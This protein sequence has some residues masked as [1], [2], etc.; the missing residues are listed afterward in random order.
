M[1]T[2]LVTG[3]N[4][5]VGLALAR[6]WAARGCLVVATARRPD[7]ATELRAL[8][9]EVP[10]LLQIHPLDVTNPADCERLARDLG[11]LAIDVLVCNAGVLSG[12]GPIEDPAYDL[13]AW[14]S[15]LMT[16]VAGVFFTIR[17]IVPLVAAA[18]AGKIAVISSIMG[19]STRA[20]GGTYAYRASKAAA[21]NLA[22]NMAPELAQRGIA[23]GAYHPGWVKTDMGGAGADITVEES[24]AGL[25]ARIDA[26]TLATTGVF[27]DYRGQPIPF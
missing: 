20:P 13:D 22:R 9:A 27:E 1:P 26:L 3:A 8:S 12:R 19:S 4:R 6:V 18:P 15:Q 5:G 21:V 24:A 10:G 17:A 2:C 16:N 7:D 14:T 23:V 25:V 11:D